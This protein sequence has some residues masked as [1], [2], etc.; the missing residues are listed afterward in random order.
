MNP[1]K[2]SGAKRR[3]NAAVRLR[4]SVDILRHF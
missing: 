2:S 1:V 4:S 3:S